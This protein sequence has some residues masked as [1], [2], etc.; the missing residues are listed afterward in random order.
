MRLK[1]FVFPES[2]KAATTQEARL[3]SYAA[4][5]RLAKSLNRSKQMGWLVG[6]VDF[7][8][9]VLPEIKEFCGPPWPPK[10][11]KRKEQNLYCPLIAPKFSRENQP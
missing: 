4:F 8:S 10:L 5:G 11:L 7:E 1:Q 6:A 9:I 2:Q 3:I